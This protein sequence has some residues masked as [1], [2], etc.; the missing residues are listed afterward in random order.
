[1]VLAIGARTKYPLHHACADTDSAAD[2]ENA[3][4]LGLQFANANLDTT[5]L[6]PSG[7]WL[8]ELNQVAHGSIWLTRAAYVHSAAANR[9]KR[10][11]SLHGGLDS[12]RRTAKLL[13]LTSIKRLP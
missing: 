4:A 8:C 7:L 11:A 9:S 12:R 2:L 3:H 6:R 1:L 10:N 5:E 13:S